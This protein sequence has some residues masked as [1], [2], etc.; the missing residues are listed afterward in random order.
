MSFAD[1]LKA[2]RQ[3]KSYS[4]AM[5]AQIIPGLSARTL[6][7]WECSQQAPPLW[8]QSLVLEKLAGAPDDVLNRR[9]I[10]PAHNSPLINVGDADKTHPADTSDKLAHASKTVVRPLELKASEDHHAEGLLKESNPPMERRKKKLERKEEPAVNVDVEPGAKT[11]AK[12][13]TIQYCGSRWVKGI[14]FSNLPH[15]DFLK[16]LG[17]S[18]INK[19][20]LLLHWTYRVNP[21][22]FYRINNVRNE[23]RSERRSESLE[24]TQDHVFEA[25]ARWLEKEGYIKRKFNDIPIT[26]RSMWKAKITEKGKRHLA[27][28]AMIDCHDDLVVHATSSD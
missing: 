7:A 19:Y 11:Y 22:Q 17:K 3:Q 8:A 18:W 28:D 24:K 16:L 10:S 25:M 9:R 6:Q 26:N 4:Q 23:R 15:I 13:E 27:E 14:M 12:L 5:A 21:V 20:S 1:Q 2:V